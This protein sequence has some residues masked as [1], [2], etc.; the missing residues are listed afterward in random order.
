MS[1]AQGKAAVIA[2]CASIIAEVDISRIE[3]RLEQGWVD[4]CYD[5][6]KGC[7]KGA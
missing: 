7:S 1:G 5:T 4:A 2:G 6:P 3:T